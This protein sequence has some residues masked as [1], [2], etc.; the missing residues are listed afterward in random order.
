MPVVL[1]EKRLEQAETAEQL[2]EKLKR[3]S[4]TECS[5]TV[6]KQKTKRIQIAALHYSE[7]KNMVKT[8]QKQEK[9]TA[10]GSLRCLSFSQYLGLILF[11]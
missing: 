9:G 6:K 5:C 3:D 10:D 8:L 7:Q 2:W 1:K 11:C 4:Q